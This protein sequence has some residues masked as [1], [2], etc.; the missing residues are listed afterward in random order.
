MK[1]PKYLHSYLIKVN[2]LLF[3][4]Q[5]PRSTSSYNPT[6]VQPNDNSKLQA[7]EGVLLQKT[8]MVLSTY[9]TVSL[10]YSVHYSTVF[11]LFGK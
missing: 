5:M 7:C 9:I 6:F 4:S 3:L 2:Q 8:E 11:S 10:K 1:E